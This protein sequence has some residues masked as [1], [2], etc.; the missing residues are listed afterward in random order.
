MA[1]LRRVANALIL[2]PH[3]GC[4]VVSPASLWTGRAK[5]FFPLAASVVL[6]FQNFQSSVFIPNACLL[7]FVFS[8]FL[9]LQRVNQYKDTGQYNTQ[10]SVSPTNS[11]LGSAG[12]RCLFSALWTWRLLPRFPGLAT[13]HFQSKPYA[14]RQPASLAYS[15]SLRS[16]R[17]PKAKWAVLPRNN[18]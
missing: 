3:L 11:H 18:T 16:P 4:R 2:F 7:L 8:S 13:M 6:R 1:D 17:D 9:L 14:W 12:A 15:V 5:A 10:Q